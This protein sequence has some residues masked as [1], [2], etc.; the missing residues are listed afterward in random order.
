[1]TVSDNQEAGDG[2]PGALVSI[3]QL[4][5][6]ASAKMAEERS[7]AK[8][9]DTIDA[10]SMQRMQEILM[11]LWQCSCRPIVLPPKMAPSL[12][13]SPTPLLPGR[14]SRPGRPGDY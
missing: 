6:E 7:I 10:A 12:I 13:A 8:E 1:M 3:D 2:L 4:Y 11:H 9:L 14:H 5:L